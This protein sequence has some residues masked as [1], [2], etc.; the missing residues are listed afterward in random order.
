MAISYRENYLRIIEAQPNILGRFVNIRRI[1]ID[2]GDG[3]FSLVFKAKDTTTNKEVAIKFYNPLKRGE[4]YRERCFEREPDILTKLKGQR[5]ILQ[6]V[7]PMSK[8]E[9]LITDV[10]TGITIPDILPFF[11]TELANSNMMQYIYSEDANA[12]QNLRYFRAMCRSIQRIH[13]AHICHRDIKPE[14]FFRLGRNHIRLGDFGTARILDG[15][16]APMQEDYLGWRGDRRYTAPEQCVTIPNNP[17]L[18]YLGDMYSLGAILFE[19]NTRQ[20]LFPFIFDNNFHDSFSQHFIL[21]QPEQREEILR[22]L[23]PDIAKNKRL[24]SINDFDNM[25]PKTIANR[26]DKLYQGLCDLDFAKRLRNFSYIFQELN[27]CENILTNELAY[28]RLIEI[29]KEWAK[30]TKEHRKALQNPSLG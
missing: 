13:K 30:K 23:V 27:A 21:I 8:F 7:A 26:I 11:V 2:G 28:I 10:N 9:R 18:F 15:N 12:I 4:T 5:D 6:L 22:A 24:P 19:M 20:L 1:N 14:N 17:G 3:N 25:V 16:I 29:R